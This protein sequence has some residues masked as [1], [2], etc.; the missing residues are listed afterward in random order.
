MDELSHITQMIADGQGDALEK[1]ILRASRPRTCWTDLHCRGLARRFGRDL[2]QDNVPQKI[3]GLAV[4][5]GTNWRAI[6]LTHAASAIHDLGDNMSVESL[7]V[8]RFQ[9]R[10]LLRKL[11]SLPV[12]TARP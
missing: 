7:D 9:P 6:E 11:L 3:G 4:A 10:R 12:I 2:P 8:G 1:R 5:A